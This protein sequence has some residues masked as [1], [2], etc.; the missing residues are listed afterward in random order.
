MKTY[1]GNLAGVCE[2]AAH[3]INYGMLI[4]QLFQLPQLQL[5]TP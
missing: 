2:Y 4:T 5:L 1:S 3:W